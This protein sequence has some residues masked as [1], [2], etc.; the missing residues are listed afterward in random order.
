[1]L[2]FKK[3]YQAGCEE[4]VDG[5]QS[6]KPNCIKMNCKTTVKCGEES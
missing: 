1:M 6:D 3:I 2:K 4:N 5:M